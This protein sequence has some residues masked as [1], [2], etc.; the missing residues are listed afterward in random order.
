MMYIIVIHIPLSADIARFPGT[1]LRVLD[2]SVCFPELLLKA[3]AKTGQ[4][5]V[6]FHARYG[7]HQDGHPSE[8]HLPEIS[9]NI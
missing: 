3:L 2:I 9:F 7:A 5:A 8:P 4:Y 6:A 1:L